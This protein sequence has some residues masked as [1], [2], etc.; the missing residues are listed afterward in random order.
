M[1]EEPVRFRDRCDAGRQLAS[2]LGRYRRWPRTVVLGLPRGGVVPAAEIAR[3]LDLPLDVV[4]ARKI[5]APGNPEFAIGAV[6]EDGAPY[7]N[8]EAIALTHASVDYLT[9]EVARQRA[10]ISQR[11]QLF[12]GGRALVLPDNATVIL[13]DDGVAT[14]AT[15]IAGI[16]ALRGLRVGHLVVALPVAPP[17]TADVLRGVVDKLI[18]ISTAQPVRGGRGILRRLSA[19]ARGRGQ[20]TARRRGRTGRRAPVAVARS[21]QRGRGCVPGALSRAHQ[22]RRQEGNVGLAAL[23]KGDVMTTKPFGGRLVPTDF[24]RAASTAAIVAAHLARALGASIDV[25]DVRGHVA[26]CGRVRRCKCSRRA[27]Q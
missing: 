6:A 4:I 5:G 9:A 23:P 16:R 26:A 27:P 19:G 11:R 13:V 1:R 22:L 18:V 7:L 21:R 2:R 17:E 20:T 10:E 15:L 14:G 3:A 12:R 25:L 8:D 24:S